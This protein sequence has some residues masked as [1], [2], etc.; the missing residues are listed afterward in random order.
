MTFGVVIRRDNGSTWAT[1][2]TTFMHFNGKVTLTRPALSKNFGKLVYQTDVPTRYNIFPFTKLKDTPET[3]QSMGVG[4][5][6]EQNG[7]WAIEFIFYYDSKA[8]KWWQFDLYLFSSRNPVPRNNFGLIIYN[9]K[10]EIAYSADTKPLQI[11]TSNEKPSSTSLIREVGMGRSIAVMPTPVTS[12]KIADSYYTCSPLAA[13]NSL[14]LMSHY[15]NP[16]AN[17]GYSSNNI[18]QGAFVGF[19]TY[20]ETAM[21]D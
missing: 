7:M 10:G 21:Y 11:F 18:F 3:F 2:D 20:I 9:N 4:R 12:T 5:I 1:P 13:G 6:F 8:Q 17:Y 15:M 19:T 14:F 16:W